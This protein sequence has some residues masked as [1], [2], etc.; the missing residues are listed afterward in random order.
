[1]HDHYTGH[2]KTEPVL[3]C[4]CGFEIKS[5]NVL[6]KHVSDHKRESIEMKKDATEDAKQDDFDYSH[7]NV[8]DFVK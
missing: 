5:K 3:I 4:L 2:H 1:M 8:K 7:I 6:Y